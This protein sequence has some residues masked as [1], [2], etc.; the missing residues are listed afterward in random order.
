MKKIIK[1]MKI[2]NGTNV[3]D[4]GAEALFGAYA[5]IPDAI[6]WKAKICKSFVDFCFPKIVNYF[7]F[8]I[9]YYKKNLQMKNS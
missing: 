9:V 5:S 2:Y 7:S 3:T 4:I 6:F 1:Q 8:F